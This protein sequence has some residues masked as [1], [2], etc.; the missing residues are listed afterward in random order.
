MEMIWGI[1]KAEVK[2]KPFKNCKDIQ[3]LTRTAFSNVTPEFVAN[4]YAHVEE[5]R[6]WYRHLHEMEPLPVKNVEDIPIDL[7]VSG[8]NIEETLEE[9]TSQ[10][11]NARKVMSQMNWIYK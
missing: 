8:E 6:T 7:P 1:A 10:L 5:Q 4:C 3:E 2:K 11:N 9:G